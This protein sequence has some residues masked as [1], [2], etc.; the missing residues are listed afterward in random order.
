MEVVSLDRIVSQIQVTERAGL[1][2]LFC[3]QPVPGTHKRPTNQENTMN[4][5]GMR[6]EVQNVSSPEA[7]TSS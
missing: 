1:F 7:S 2:T 6:I 3:P 4:T 5:I